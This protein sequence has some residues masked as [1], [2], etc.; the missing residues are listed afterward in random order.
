MFGLHEILYIVEQREF[1]FSKEAQ[2]IT[3]DSLACS[4]WVM[5][6]EKI[7]HSWAKRYYVKN[8]RKVRENI[9]VYEC[10]CKLGLT[11]TKSVLGASME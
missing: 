8:A 1:F 10:I 4:S 2:T 11:F 9:F 3:E 7:E 5:M 6:M